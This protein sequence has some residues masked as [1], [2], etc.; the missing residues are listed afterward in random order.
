MTAC[1]GVLV[2]V[3]VNNLLHLVALVNSYEVSHFLVHYFSFK[4]LNPGFFRAASGVCFNLQIIE[5]N[6]RL[7]LW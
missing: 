2:L 6:K 5:I 1:K 7:L 3:L 4:Q